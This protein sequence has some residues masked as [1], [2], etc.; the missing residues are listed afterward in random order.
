M[1]SQD[2][3][4]YTP[5]TE[6]NRE[7][8]LEVLLQVLPGSGSILEIASGTGEHAVF[9]CVQAQFSFV[10]TNRYKSAIKSQYLSLG[11][12]ENIVESRKV[13]SIALGNSPYDYRTLKLAR[14]RNPHG[15]S[16]R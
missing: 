2:A 7:P 12:I 3:R 16:D 5:A 15:L 9:Y 1:T 14:T 6:R 4:Q 11:V 10:A 8:I 13:L